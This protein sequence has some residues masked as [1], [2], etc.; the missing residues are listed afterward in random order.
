MQ[1]EML[2]RIN[3]WNAEEKSTYLAVCLRGSAL[4]VLSNMP[5]DKLYNCDDLISALEARFGNAHQSELHKIKA[6]KSG[7][8]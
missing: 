5:A 7:Q 3:Q 8:T 4:A 6:E 1:F 2:A